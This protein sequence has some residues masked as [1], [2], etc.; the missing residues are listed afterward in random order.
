V[1]FDEFQNPF[2][3]KFH[4][5]RFFTKRLIM[6][7]KERSSSVQRT[8]QRKETI[9]A[10]TWLSGTLVVTLQHTSQAEID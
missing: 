5:I 8:E 9:W 1:N 4:Q 6:L 2:A 10:M 7:V 3:N